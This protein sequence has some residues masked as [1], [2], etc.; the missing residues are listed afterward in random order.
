MTESAISSDASDSEAGAEL[1][2]LS[3]EDDGAHK[4]PTTPR[5]ITGVKSS[6]FSVQSSSSPL[7]TS[8][9]LIN[10]SDEAMGPES[11]AMRLA[12]ALSRGSNHPMSRAV[13]QAAGDAADGGV[14][15][16]MFEQVRVGQLARKV[17]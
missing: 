5:S 8:S 1:N 6:T 14:G 17:V 15:V 10:S 3:S 12:V 2:S 13:V 4:E 9:D 11:A 16:S 7:S